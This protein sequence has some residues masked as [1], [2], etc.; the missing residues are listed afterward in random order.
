MSPIAPRSSRLPWRRSVRTTPGFTYAVASARH[1]STLPD[2]SLTTSE[3]SRPR[4]SVR[5][6]ASPARARRA[7]AASI[8][9]AA[10]GG[11]RGRR[12]QHHR[13]GLDH[14]AE[15]IAP[16]MPPRRG[17]TGLDRVD[18]QLRAREVERDEASLALAP[19]GGMDVPDHRGPCV[20]IVVRAVDAREL[21]AAVD[22]IPDQPGIGGGLRGQR[23]HDARRAVPGRRAEDRDGLLRQHGTSGVEVDRW[24]LAD[25]RRN[26]PAREAVEH[27]QHRIE[28]REDVRLHPPERREPQARERV[29]HVAHVVPPHGE[30]VEQVA[31]ALAA[32]R[33]GT[34][35]CL[36]ELGLEDE[37]RPAQLLDGAQ[38]ARGSD[39][40]ADVL[41]SDAGARGQRAPFGA[42]QG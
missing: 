16:G 37:R 19:R 40:A 8:G 18:A 4:L 39:V 35:Q 29:L 17:R 14:V 22:E 33:R 10:V 38:G 20:A 30:V 25:V 26:R 36:G 1:T 12:R 34:G 41:G 27:V 9:T 21:H 31:Q 15:R 24:R 32:H 28:R 3:R 7:S 13:G 6:I 23:D 11:V 2:D 5:S 42:R